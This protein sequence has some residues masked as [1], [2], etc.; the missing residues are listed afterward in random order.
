M[1]Q[2]TANVATCYVSVLSHSGVDYREDTE[3][4]TLRAGTTEMCTNFVIINDSDVEGMET[5]SVTLEALYP[6]SVNISSAVVTII[7]DDSK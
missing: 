6:I 4:L 3:L 5:F 1:P 7:D 2:P